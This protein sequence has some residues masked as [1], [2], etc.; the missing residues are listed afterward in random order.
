[1]LKC[2]AID[3]EP[4]AL[5]ILKRYMDKIPFAVMLQVFREPIAAIDFLKKEKADLIFLD[6]NM[7]DINGLQLAGL[8]PGTAIIFTTAYPQYAIDSYEH[9]TVDYLLKP[10]SFD[11]FLKAVNKAYGLQALSRKATPDDTDTG[12]KVSIPVKSGN[13]QYQVAIDDIIYMEKQ[14][15]YISLALSEQ[16]IL[17]RE[18]MYGIF[19]LIPRRKFIRIH[20]SYIV[21]LA[22]ISHIEYGFVVAGENKIPIGATYRQALKQAYSR[23]TG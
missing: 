7:P 23:K 14:G 17:I 1:M 2:I 19:D 11:R 12:S 4:R 15:N 9:N 10:I 8:F 3:D 22:H 21:A 18:S 5:D 13:K 20:K 6:I 16:K